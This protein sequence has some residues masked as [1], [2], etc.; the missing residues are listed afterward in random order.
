MA[1]ERLID[2]DKD[3]KYRIRKN[4]DGED[5]LYIDE[6][7]Q[8]AEESEEVMFDVPEFFED[9][10]E[11]A[12]MTPEQ[13]LAKREAQEREKAQKQEKIK[14]LLASAQKDCDE[15]KYATALDCLQQVVALD[16]KNGEAYALRMSIYTRNF[17]DYSQIAEASKYADEVSDYTSKEIKAQMF[18]RAS[19]E[20]EA[21]IARLK[22]REAELDRENE[23]QKALRAKKFVR[24]RNVALA[25][26]LGFLLCVVGFGVGT[27]VCASLILSVKTNKYLIMTICFGIVAFIALCACLVALRRLIVTGRRVRLNKRNTAT[28]L[29]RE[30]IAVRAELKAFNLVYTALKGE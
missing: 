15:G 4:A 30:L 25:L 3:K 23:E 20:L 18:E 9:N 17:T 2:T 5:E 14:A 24:D 13:L 6:S 10:E 11:E 12:V 16:N 29:G 8:E 28:K 1:E 19:K 26:F 27:G 21:N 7:Q 22:E